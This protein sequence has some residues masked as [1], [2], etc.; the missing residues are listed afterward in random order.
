MTDVSSEQLKTKFPQLN[1][2]RALK[3]GG[4]KAVYE[5]V[6]NK[7][8][9]VVLKIVTHDGKDD[10]CQLGRDIGAPQRGARSSDRKDPRRG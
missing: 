1:D 3:T 8:G 7:Y 6:H 5:A 4:Q 2:I 9:N 10:R